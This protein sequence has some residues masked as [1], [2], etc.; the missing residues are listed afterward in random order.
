MDDNKAGTIMTKAMNSPDI[1]E[2]KEEVFKTGF[3][4]LDEKVIRNTP[5]DDLEY[6]SQDVK[7]AII[8][9]N[10]ILAKNKHHEAIVYR[11]MLSSPLCIVL[12]N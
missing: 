11:W 4:L 8:L 5:I 3:F 12:N 10:N 7:K 6:S 2:F 1:M 9:L